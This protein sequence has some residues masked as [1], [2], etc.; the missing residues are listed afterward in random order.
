MSGGKKAQNWKWWRLYTQLSSDI[1][2]AI[3]KQAVTSNL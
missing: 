1:L 3:S 2:S